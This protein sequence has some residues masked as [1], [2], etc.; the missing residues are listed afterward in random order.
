MP[1]RTLLSGE[2]RV[3][4]KTD[5]SSVPGERALEGEGAPPQALVGGGA[6][7]PESVAE[8]VEAEG[9]AA[10][11]RARP[12]QDERPAANAL[13]FRPDT[14]PR[15]VDLAELPGLVADDDNFVWVDL[16]AYDEDDLRA[17]AGLLDLHPLAVQAALSSWQRPQLRVFKNHFFA[18]AT[19][20]RLD[21]A[22]YKVHATQLDMFVGN[23]FLVSAHRPPVPFAERILLRARQ[24]PELVQL[25]AAFML[26]IILDELLAYYESLNE[27]VQAEVEKVEE[28][29]L[30]DTSEGFLSDLLRFKRYAF[31]L[32]QLLDQHREIFAA[33]LRPDFRRVSGS[34]GEGF[35]RD[36]ETRLMVLRDTL[37]AAREAANGAFDIYVSHVSHRTNA[38]I[39]VLTMISAVLFSMTVI[40]GL[41]STSI[42]GLSIYKPVDFALMLALMLAVSGAILFTF[43]RKNWF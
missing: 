19:V 5:A 14:E 27:H 35:F 17:V 43:H 4:P 39:K 42:Q 13:L 36:L 33:F 26:Y 38:V 20:A 23:N 16:S 41:F 2:R 1:N 31:A 21:P 9:A 10:S 25:D 29:A 7:I 40:I 15:E 37:L 18:S 6:D 8:I 24:S 30:T 22:V 3:A 34:D 32:S 11:T 28:R 12:A